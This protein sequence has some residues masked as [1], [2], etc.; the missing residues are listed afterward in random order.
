MH[1]LYDQAVALFAEAESIAAAQ[2]DEDVRL[3]AIGLTAR[4]HYA[5]ALW[6]MLDGGAPANPLI[7]VAA[8]DAAASQF[9]SLAPD[10]WRFQ[11]EFSSTT[12]ANVAA[13]WIN[14]RN[15]MVVGAAY[16]QAD[17]SGKKICS[18]HNTA[19]PDDGILYED[20]IDGVPDPA[21]RR[22]V[23]EF[24]AGVQFASQ[25]VIGAREMHLMLAESALQQG[26]AAGFATHINHVRA[27]EDLTPY[28]ANVH[29]IAP[30]DLLIHTRLVNLFLQ[31]MRRLGDLYRF[32]IAV[33]DW[34]ASS[35]AATAPGTV[36]PISDEERL[37]NC[38]FNGTC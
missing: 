18:P 37:S 14:Q 24:I 7:S 10:D 31:P 13:S 8:A 29:A 33:P 15:E 27:M 22:Y 35:E 21:L 23:Y 11:F 36:F 12:T 28:D 20:P 25:T 16:A 26:D 9:L 4:A 32:G 3:A 34:V 17:A 1:T 38:Y 2:G 19:C 5:K 30:Q 6:Q